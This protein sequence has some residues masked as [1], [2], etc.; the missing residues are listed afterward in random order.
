ML[1]LVP[2]YLEGDRSPQDSTIDRVLSRHDGSLPERGTPDS[3]LTQVCMYIPNHH[4]IEIRLPF[5]DRHPL[6]D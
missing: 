5:A 4:G 6:A 1:P 3:G 2:A